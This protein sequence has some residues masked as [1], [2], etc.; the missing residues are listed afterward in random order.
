MPIKKKDLS[1]EENGVFGVIPVY[2]AWRLLVKPDVNRASESKIH[3]QIKQITTKKKLNE[4]LGL[5]THKFI[6]R[7]TLLQL[8]IYIYTLLSLF[9][10]YILQLLN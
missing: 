5:F 6:Y 4:F 10:N 8:F 9:I 3:C 7:E 2:W 1:E